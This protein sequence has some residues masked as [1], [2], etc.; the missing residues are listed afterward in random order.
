MEEKGRLNMEEGRREQRNG[1]REKTRVQRMKD[2][3]FC[4]LQHL[5]EANNEL[6]SNVLLPSDRINLEGLLQSP[7]PL[8]GKGSKERL[9]SYAS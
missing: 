1:K 2:V 9:L 5:F 8:P 6:T 4:E 3:W 7:N